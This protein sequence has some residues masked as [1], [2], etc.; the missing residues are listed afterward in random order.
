MANP[1][2]IIGGG[3]AGLAA[4][5]CLAQ[6]GIG[7]TLYEAAETLGG[8]AR[9]IEYGDQ[10]LDNGQHIMLGAYTALQQLIDVVAPRRRSFLR[11]RLR[12]SIDGQLTLQSWPLPA[13]LNLAL[14]FLFA[15]GVSWPDRLDAL[16]FL[17]RIKRTAPQPGLSVDQWLATNGQNG[18]LATLMWRPLCVAALNTPAAVASARLFRT[19]LLAA[20]GGSAENSD[21]MFPSVDLSTLFPE[22]AASYITAHGGEIRASTAVRELRQGTHD[23]EI[24]TRK[25]A[26]RYA[27]V[28]CAT[29]P[30]QAMHLLKLPQLAAFTRFA[31]Q[32]RFEPIYTVYLSYASPPKLDFPMIGM[33]GGLTQW[34]FD[35]RLAGLQGPQIACVISASGPHQALDRSAILSSV[36]DELRHAFGWPPPLWSKLVI[37]KQA[38]F[39]AVAG[40]PRPPQK[41]ELDGFYLAGDYTECIYPA[42]LE[43]AVRSGQLCAEHIAAALA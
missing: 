38:T 15:S 8:R 12:L 2:A 25:S 28:I 39:S 6:R 13:P 18:R 16:R 1:V 17:S 29:A 10:N 31:E 41:T 27:Q 24:V 9:R 30:R 4:G 19:T 14:G 20:F 5:V 35:R 34:V 22:P 37:E 23:F 7:V 32:A 11:R 26:E 21:L 3:Y 36:A 43:A 42:T 33:A 40:L